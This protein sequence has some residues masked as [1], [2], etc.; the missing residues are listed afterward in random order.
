MAHINEKTVTLDE[1]SSEEDEVSYL[2]RKKGG[3]KKPAE[4]KA[5]AAK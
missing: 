3:A 4:K 2:E 5:K 1:L